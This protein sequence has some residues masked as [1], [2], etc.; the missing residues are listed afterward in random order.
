MRKLSWIV[1]KRVLL[2]KNS[3]TEPFHNLKHAKETLNL[4]ISSY[5]DKTK[6][7]SQFYIIFLNQIFLSL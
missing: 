6:K 4:R 2:S 7:G 1:R 5:Q 3:K